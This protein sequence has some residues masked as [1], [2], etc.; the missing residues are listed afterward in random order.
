MHFLTTS[1]LLLAGA[2]SLLAPFVPTF[3][4]TFALTFVPTF[5]LEKDLVMIALLHNGYWTYDDFDS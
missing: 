5:V 2:G 4:P 3:V 1:R